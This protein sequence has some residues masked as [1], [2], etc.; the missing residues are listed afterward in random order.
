MTQHLNR[1]LAPLQERR[2][3]YERNPQTVWGLLEEG[4]KKARAVAQSTMV[5]VRAAVKLA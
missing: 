3:T 1:A 5:Q 2:T 4:T